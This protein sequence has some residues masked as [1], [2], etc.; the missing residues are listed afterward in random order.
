[1][2]SIYTEAGRAI[3]TS[4]DRNLVGRICVRLQRRGLK[5]RMQY[6]GAER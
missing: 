6:D 4:S 3:Y 2:F 1:M 5:V